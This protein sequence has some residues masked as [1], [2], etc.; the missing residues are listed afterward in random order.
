MMPLPTPQQL[1]YL[2]AL[3]EH[4]HFSRAALCANDAETHASWKFT[5][6]GVGECLVFMPNAN[7]QTLVP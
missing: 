3:A 4:Q 7:A 1:R 5:L 6:E 2:L